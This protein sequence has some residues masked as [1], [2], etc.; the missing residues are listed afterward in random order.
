M[1]LFQAGKFAVMSFSTRLVSVVKSTT[2]R[3]EER[4]TIQNVRRASGFI[5][6]SADE[7]SKQSRQRERQK[8]VK[9]V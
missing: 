5:K 3:V 9:P 6:P 1:S 4:K 2:N 7:D 8:K